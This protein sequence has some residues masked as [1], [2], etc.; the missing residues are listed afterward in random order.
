LNQIADA[1]NKKIDNPEDRRGFPPLLVPPN[2]NSQG[3]GFLRKLPGIDNILIGI[4]RSG[5]GKA[6]GN[7]I[8]FALQKEKIRISIKAVTAI[9]FQI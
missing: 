7:V 6:S 8:K 1:C 2:R 5:G 9:Y 3:Q 4:C